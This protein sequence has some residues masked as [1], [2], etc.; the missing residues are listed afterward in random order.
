MRQGGR[1]ATVPA[2]LA[3]DGR[4]AGA[5][6]RGGREAG[7]PAGLAHDDRGAAEPAATG[8]RVTTVLVDDH[9][10]FRAGLR[11]LLEERGIAVVGEAPTAA[12]GVRAVA[13]HVPDVAVVDLGLPDA[14]GVEAIRAIAARAPA[15]A[16]L[17]LTVSEAERDLTEVVAAGARG[18]LLKDAP[19]AEIAG[20]VRAVADGAASLSPRIAAATLAQ[21]R[22]V[23][24]ATPPADAN[25]TPREREVLR[26]VAAGADNATIAR[27]LVIS[28]HTAKNHVSAILAR[29]GVANRIQAAVTAVRDGLV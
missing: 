12:A 27:E 22:A 29:L 26:L 24:R 14:P 2:G 17:V 16:V 3:R 8:R 28:P 19:I 20:A 15:T 13:H 7:G 5:L 18:Y 1:E 10:L 23:E 21:L 11:E 6:A 4:E 25:L 9:T